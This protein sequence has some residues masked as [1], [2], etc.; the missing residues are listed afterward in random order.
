ME[1]KEQPESG[2]SFLTYTFNV[3]KSKKFQLSL[4]L[5]R[6]LLHQRYITLRLEGRDCVLVH[7]LL[8]SIA[9]NYDGEIVKCLD[10]PSDLEAVC[11]KYGDRNALFA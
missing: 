11:Q 6:L 3:L 9:I 1:R 7:H 10:C 8:A 5:A 2:C 4:V